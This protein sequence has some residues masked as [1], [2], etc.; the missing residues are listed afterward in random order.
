MPQ[1]PESAAAN[2]STLIQFIQRHSPSSQ[3]SFNNN[4]LLFRFIFFLQHF[5]FHCIRVEGGLNQQKKQ[6]KTLCSMV[7]IWFI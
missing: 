5:V 1:K 6:G 4:F 2:S 7:E 3:I